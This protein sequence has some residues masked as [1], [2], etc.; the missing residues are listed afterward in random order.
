MKR[1]AL[2]LPLLLSCADAR[3][4][5]RPYVPDPAKIRAVLAQKWPTPPFDTAIVLGCPA[6]LDGAPSLCQRCRVKTAVRAYQK[7]VVKN[8]I[9]SGAAAHSP[10]VEAEV[11]ARLALAHGIPE[12][13]VFR[14]QRALTTWQNL[15]FSLEIMRAHGLSTALV[16]STAEHLP[17]SRR[18]ARFWGLDDAH[19]GYEACD[20]DLPR[21]LDEPEDALLPAPETGA[22]AENPSGF[23]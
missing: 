3:D 4:V 23:R 9:F 18:I 6:R 1:L 22:A 5:F 14:E 17:R 15:R 19:A 8:L 13:H 2:L 16:V 10:A 11:M 7:G 20:L 12:A 21:K